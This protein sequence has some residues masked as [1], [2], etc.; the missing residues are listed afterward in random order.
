MIPELPR[1]ELAA[2]LNDVQG[3]ARG[4]VVTALHMEMDLHLWGR[5]GL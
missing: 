3:D 1:T 5:D 4:R 2:W